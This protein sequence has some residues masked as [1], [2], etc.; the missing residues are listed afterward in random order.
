MMSKL[1][2][3]MLGAAATVCVSTTA[4]LNANASSPELTFTGPAA[5]STTVHFDVMLPLHNVDKLKSLLAAQQDRKSKLFH[6]WLTPAQFGAQFGPDR[7]T[8]HNIA[9]EMQSRGFVVE[10]EETRSIRVTGT[11]D[12]VNRNFGVHL[13]TAQSS[14]DGSRY[15]MTDEAFVMPPKLA[16]AGAKIF[17][18][19]PFVHH[20]DARVVKELGSHPY[21]R[22][23][24]TGGYW[25]DDLKQAYQYPAVTDMVKTAGGTTAPFDGTGATIGA[26]MS[27]NVFPNDIKAMFDNENWAATTG[28]SDPVLNRIELIDGGPTTFPN[29]AT[30]EVSLDT[31]Q[32]IGGAPG[33]SVVLYAIPDLSDGSVLAGYVDADENNDLDVLSSSFGECE[34]FYGAAYNHGINQQDIL[35][36]YD[37]LFMQGNSQG[38][39]FL[40]SS[41]DSAGKG[42]LNV[43][44]LTGGKNPA[45]IPG[46]ET[47]A[48]DPNVTAVGGTN[49]VTSYK[50]GSLN[51]A[52]KSENAWDD[53]ELP[54]DPYGVGADA[55]GGSWGAGGGYSTIFA[56]PSY[57]SQ[58]TTG[59]TTWRAVPDVGMQVGGCPLGIAADYHSKQNEC[60]VKSP[61]DGNGDPDRSYVVTAIGGTFY[62]L[63]GTS[64]SSPEFAGLVAHLVELNGRQGNLNPYI[65]QQAAMQ[66]MGMGTIFHTNIPG[67]NGIEQTNINTSYSLSTGVGTPIGTPFLGQ[68]SAT[69][70]GVPQSTSNP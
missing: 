43:A 56:A 2:A 47:P 63:I 7:A 68:S 15:T 31:Q 24:S 12:L 40:A 48:T 46:V 6:K 60:F 61:Q 25:Y 16:A 41:G 65:Y 27:S 32:E 38:I 57:Q 62:G 30:A 53:P 67:Y 10:R 14:I 23:S 13:K 29:G 39:T 42:C 55:K 54:Y 33:A 70:A 34:L 69:P 21:N 26:M 52:Y 59:S 4:S 36:A 58:V 3:A 8:I 17:S 66:A 28:T 11:A 45:F 64:V 19:A 44:Y 20:T 37:E 22:Q 1:K 9:I 5:E 18:F 51:S 35:N 50:K 49:L